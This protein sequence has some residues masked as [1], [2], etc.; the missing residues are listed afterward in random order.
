M[1]KMAPKTKKTFEQFAEHANRSGLHPYDW[2]RFYRFVR[3]AYRHGSMI[4]EQDVKQAL[5]KE[6]FHEEYAIDISSIYGHCWRMLSGS[7]SPM[8]VKRRRKE[9]NE[10]MDAHWASFEERLSSKDV[11]ENQR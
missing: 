2:Q 3:V 6:G 5:M 11:I 8:G 10:E 4:W 9:I 1:E 7:S